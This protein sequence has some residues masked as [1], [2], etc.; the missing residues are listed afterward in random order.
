MSKRKVIKR[1]I[2]E[3]QFLTLLSKTIISPSKFDSK[4]TQTSAVRHSDD[5][6]ETHT[7]LDRIEDISG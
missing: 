5:C 2:T 4:Q 1:D 7:R 6:S 3:D